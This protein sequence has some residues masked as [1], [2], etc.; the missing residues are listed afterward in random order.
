MNIY[1]LRHGQTDYNLSGKFQGQVDVLL[2]ENGIAQAKETAKELSKVKFD[3]VFSSPLKRAIQTV[4]FVAKDK[5]EIDKR[6]IERSFGKLEGQQSIENFEQKVEEYQIETIE[7]LKERVYSFLDE[8]IEEYRYCDN[9][10]IA[11]HACVAKMIECYFSKLEYNE[12][13]QSSELC[14]GQYK[15]YEIR[16][17]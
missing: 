5:I 3:K 7:H 11:T 4:E 12:V 17:K 1:V 6:L 14:N 8:I 9:I 15:R 13:L 10:L 16:G 2:N